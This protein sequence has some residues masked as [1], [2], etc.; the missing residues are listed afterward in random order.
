MDASYIKKVYVYVMRHGS[1]EEGKNG[2]LTKHGIREVH[3]SAEN[4]LANINFDAYYH[5]GKLRALMTIQ[6]ARLAIND[7]SV[8]EIKENCFF[9][10]E[11]ASDEG[12]FEDYKKKVEREMASR[13]L[14]EPTVALWYAAAPR[15]IDSL[16]ERIR[17]GLLKVALAAIIE[18][19]AQK[20]EYN[21]LVGS[22][23][24]LAEL[25]GRENH[26]SSLCLRTADIEK[27][28]ITFD[29]RDVKIASAQFISR[30]F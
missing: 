19:H 11:G 17:L 15:M 18:N 6:E 14:S 9:G 28:E 5:S 26:N 1:R 27:Y 4:N 10:F 22:H 13:H 20:S 30:G 29:G 7:Q 2:G 12:Y 16:R 24:P 21:I 3:S 23:S 8:K 25:A